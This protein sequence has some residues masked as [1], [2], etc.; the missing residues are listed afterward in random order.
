VTRRQRW[1][2]GLSA[3][4]VMALLSVPLAVVLPMALPADSGLSARTVE[5]TLWEGALRQADVAGLPL[6]DTRV[7]FDFLPF[8]VG[9]ARMGFA[10]ATLRGILDMSSGSFGLSRGNGTVD[11]AGRLRPL[12][13]SR[14]TF[15]DVAVEY[16]NGRCVSAKGR[17]R[18]EV[19]TDI[20]G[21]ALPGG[22]SGTLRCNGADLVVPLAGQSGM[23]RVDLRVAASGNWRA[24]L[25]VRTSDPVIAGKLLSSGFSSGP[26]GYTVR[27]SGAL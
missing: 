24:D 14:F 16:R 26:A 18:A 13:L 2:I 7:G 5:G 17:V 19:A 6:G 8:F 10:S 9:Q 3:A 4:A 12:P 23:E 27:V 1:I 11:L 22:M 20:G 25:S 15:D 21:L